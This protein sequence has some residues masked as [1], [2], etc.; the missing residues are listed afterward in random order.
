MAGAFSLAGWHFSRNPTSSSSENR[1]AQAPDSE[2][3]KTGSEA[4]Y[5]YH[6][7]GDPSKGKKDAPSALNEVI[8]PNVTLPK[9]RPAIH[10]EMG[11]LDEEGGLWA[12]GRMGRSEADRDCRVF[13]DEDY[14]ACTSST[15]SGVRKATRLPGLVD[16]RLLCLKGGLANCICEPPRNLIRKSN[17][18]SYN[19]P[20]AAAQSYSIWQ[21]SNI[22]ACAAATWLSLP[23]KLVTALQS[24]V[25]WMVAPGIRKMRIS[26]YLLP[27]VLIQTLLLPV[28]D[29]RFQSRVACRR[30]SA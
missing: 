29:I 14:R 28:F 23:P 27:R 21:W 7:H 24:Y 10:H 5:Q 26:S 6:P 9:V 22:T 2:P 11:V 8:I 3:W 13:A 1:V 12:F 4:K 17:D 18:D 25:S 20:E 30:A 19:L 15:T 16:E